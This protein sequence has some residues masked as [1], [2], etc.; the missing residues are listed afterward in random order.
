V[1]GKLFEFREPMGVH[2]MVDFK[3]TPDPI[4]ELLFTLFLWPNCECDMLTP[5]S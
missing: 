5:F 2:G 1:L 4:Q 3:S